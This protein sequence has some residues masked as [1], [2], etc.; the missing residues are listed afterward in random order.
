MVS[1]IADVLTHAL[2]RALNEVI[3][4]FHSFM[5]TLLGLILVLSGLLCYGH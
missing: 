2:V 4:S 1:V 5:Q 3:N